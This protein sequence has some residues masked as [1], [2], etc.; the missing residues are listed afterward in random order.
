LDT[1]DGSTIKTIQVTWFFF[2]NIIVII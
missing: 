1:T 2:T